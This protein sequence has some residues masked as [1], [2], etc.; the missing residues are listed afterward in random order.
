MSDSRALMIGDLL[1]RNSSSTSS[2]FKSNNTSSAP[3]I[4]NSI[5]K[6]RRVDSFANLLANRNKSSSSTA[7]PNGNSSAIFKASSNANTTP[8][9]SQ[10]NL[11][12][13][14][15]A[16]SNRSEAMHL[17]SCSVCGRAIRSPRDSRACSSC[18]KWAH[19]E[20]DKEETS[21]FS[22]YNCLVCRKSSL[23]ASDAILHTENANPFLTS[24][25]ESDEEEMDFGVRIGSSSTV[26]GKRSS[27]QRRQSPSPAN[28]FG[29][30]TSF[31]GHSSPAAG[32]SA[33]TAHYNTAGTLG[34]IDDEL[35]AGDSSQCGGVDLRCNLSGIS[36][37]AATGTTTASS[38]S[39]RDSPVAHNEATISDNDEYHP[40]SNR[41]GEQQSA[42]GGRSHAKKK[43]GVPRKAPSSSTRGTSTSMRTRSGGKPPATSYANI[44][45]EE[46]DEKN[47]RGKRGRGANKGLGK[48]GG[49]R[50]RRGGGSSNFFN[51]ITRKD[52]DEKETVDSNS[53]GK[54]RQNDENDYIRTAVV[55][56][57]NDKFMISIS[58]CLICGSVGKDVE[59]TMVTCTSCAQSYHTYC[60]GM[61]DK[62]NST[63]L[64][65]GWRC[66]DCTVCEGC[67]SGKDESNLLLCDEC[68]VSYHTYCLDPRLDR[69]PTDLGGV[70]GVQCVREGLCETCYS[71]R[72][73]MKCQ[74]LYELG[75]L[76]IKCQRCVRWCH[77]KCEDLLTEE[78][79]ENAA[80]NA[81]RCSLCRP[82][83]SSAYNDYMNMSVII[84][85]VMV[86]KTAAD[87]IQNARRSTSFYGD[88][89]ALGLPR[90]QSY[91]NTDDGDLM[92]E[93]ENVVQCIGSGGRGSRGGGRW[94][95]RKEGT[96]NWRPRKPRRPQ[97]EDNYPGPI[98]ESF[99]GYAAV[100]SRSLADIVVNEPILGEYTKS[101]LD[102]KKTGCE[103]SEQSADA[104][105][106][107]QEQDMLGD[108][109]VGDNID[110]DFDNLDFNALIDEADDDEND[111]QALEDSMNDGFSATGSS[112]L[113]TG[114]CSPSTSIGVG[115]A[116]I[117]HNGLFHLQMQQD[118]QRKR[119]QQ[120]QAKLNSSAAVGVV[121]RSS[122]Q[123]SELSAMQEKVN[124][125]TER[126]EEDEPLG[127]KSTKAAVLYANLRHSDFK[128]CYPLWSERV[129]QINK[130]WRMLDADKRQEYVDMARKNRANSTNKRK[131]RRNDSSSNLMLQA[132]GYSSCSSSD[133]VNAN[134]S[135]IKQA[136]AAANL[137]SQFHHSID[138]TSALEDKFKVPVIPQEAAVNCSPHPA[139]SV[140]EMLANRVPM[141]NGMEGAVPHGHMGHHFPGHEANPH[142]SMQHSHPQQTQH[143]QQLI[144]A[145]AIERHKILRKQVFD[146][147]QEQHAHELELTKMRKHKKAL[148]SKHRE[149]LKNQPKQEEGAEP[150]PINQQAIEMHKS[151]DATKRDIQT[152]QK[153]SEKCKQELREHVGRL[154]EFEL[155]HQLSNGPVGGGGPAATGLIPPPTQLATSQ[156][157]RGQ[158][159]QQNSAPMIMNPTTPSSAVFMRGQRVAVPS[160]QQVQTA[161]TTAAI[162]M[163]IA[164]RL[165]LDQTS[166]GSGPPTPNSGRTGSSA[167]A[168]VVRPGRGR[169][170]KKPLLM[171]YQPEVRAPILGS[172]L[173]SSLQSSLE[174]DVYDV[175]DRMV[176]YV[177]F[178]G[179]TN[180]SVAVRRILYSQAKLLGEN[181]PGQSFDANDPPKAKKK[182]QPMKKGQLNNEPN[183]HELI[184]ERIQTQLDSVTFPKRTL[185]QYYSF[186]KYIPHYPD[187]T[188]LPD[189]S[190]QPFVKGNELGQFSLSFMPDYYA[191]VEEG[192]KPINDA[193]LYPKS[194]AE[195]CAGVNM[196]ALLSGDDNEFADIK[197]LDF[198]YDENSLL[199][200]IVQPLNYHLKPELRFLSLAN[201]SDRSEI[202]GS[203]LLLGSCSV[204]KQ[205]PIAPHRSMFFQK[206]IDSDQEC[207]ISLVVEGEGAANTQELINQLQII[208]NSKEPLKLSIET[209]PQ[210]PDGAE[211]H[212]GFG[213]ASTSIQ[214]PIKMEVNDEA[215]FQVTKKEPTSNKR[216]RYCQ[217]Q[218]TQSS[219][220]ETMSRLGLTPPDEENSTVS[221]CSMPC[222]YKFMVT[223]KVPLSMELLDRAEKYAGVDDET[224]EK[225]RQ[226]SADS[227]AKKIHQGQFDS[228]H[229]LD[230]K[231]SFF[232]QT[233]ALQSPFEDSVKLE[234]CTESNILELIR[235]PREQ[236]VRAADLPA[237]VQSIENLNAAI[238]GEYKWK[239][240]SWMV[241]DSSL[242]DSFQRPHDEVRQKCASIHLQV[243]ERNRIS[244]RSDDTRHCTLCG[245]SGDGEQ[246]LTGRLLNVDANEWVHVNCALWSSEVHETEDGAL[247]N[248]EAAIRRAKSVACQLCGNPGA[249]LKC[250]KLD[251]RNNEV[252]FHLSCAKRTRGYFVRDKTFY[253]SLHEVRQEAQITRLD[254]LRRIYVQREENQLLAKI[255]NHS[256]STDMM[257]RV[258]SLIFHK[259]GQLLPEQLKNFH[260]ENYI[261]PIGYRIT[262]IFWSLTNAHERARYECFVDEQNNSPEFC[263]VFESRELREKSPNAAWNRILNSVMQAREKA[264]NMLKFFPN[265][266]SGDALFGFLEPA[267]TKMTESLP[268][269]DQL[270]SYTFKHGGSPL[271]DLPLAVN[272]SGCARCEP[273]FRTLIKHR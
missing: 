109:F 150:I 266:M 229:R 222:Y 161:A 16:A 197:L 10:Q 172:V 81:F 52:G 177:A 178:G 221:F 7:L 148:I 181:S 42:R 217:Q 232:A 137:Q 108:I 145:G 255:F 110:L 54:Q 39:A 80:E 193:K 88:P 151:A 79:V 25:I 244:D 204:D 117:K 118:D 250:Y 205:P 188:S 196:A 167:S 123:H 147:E 256:Y 268:G 190:G 214:H 30:S 257:M 29:I 263:V 73:C 37:P 248:V 58:L 251:C 72:K 182:R 121:Q 180:D 166:Q 186:D 9:F 59:G 90:S 99:F 85:N 53:N 2:N 62:L 209:P 241:C 136:Q 252:S 104:L 130:V 261:F 105:R 153:L 44:A 135:A 13:V 183:E 97:L 112:G 100:D 187:V 225:L 126:W 247:L 162:P 91:E 69:I 35:F 3:I 14:S 140:H 34:S 103:L 238:K 124:Q 189:R 164:A 228:D 71:L 47:E 141:R 179:A 102:S 272:P 138:S 113:I 199:S 74:R 94:W 233:S 215:M 70:N 66:L 210:S 208:L 18:K 115:L 134:I 129:K 122:S 56:N 76:L 31:S 33:I 219:I 60:V 5:A 51:S 191:N 207:K 78:Q 139:G 237:L 175:L 4:S 243:H 12:G 19:I 95:T 106:T 264:G 61:H 149:L 271:M 107:E 258:G 168:E 116:P 273:C 22:A 63:V 48:G 98:Q 240:H 224:I 64:K 269:V 226:I 65:R 211:E 185:E 230:L 77:G 86:N 96:Q 194:M 253:C 201:L 21:S 26:T 15:S 158:N 202:Q 213:P 45:Y 50:G 267:I 174:K 49:S 152:R 114:M 128:T 170:R 131:T 176:N 231:T 133:V 20:C 203:C 28:I 75:D 68:D 27:R 23:A 198:D 89:A 159:T 119:Q 254:A 41:R 83:L 249:T 171:D 165:E 218:I 206:S 101:A 8:S 11:G 142:L 223:C 38:S 40:P 55:T 227:F 43:P 127:E 200:G 36:S 245:E 111:D 120:L 46:R 163:Q 93:F 157:F 234:D 82:Q 262:R 155:K 239:G 242:I 270:Y 169:K 260:N 6:A 235:Q 184:L 259:I 144:D 265:Q 132:T 192:K 84:D 125:A 146:L 173:Y 92:D 154:Q 24:A 212:N 216:C 246:E 195:I 32:S 57:A 143:Q 156:Q 17:S 160:Q 87:N 1:F 220:E 67:G 236:I